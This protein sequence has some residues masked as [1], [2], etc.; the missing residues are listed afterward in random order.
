VKL[1][2]LDV[3]KGTIAF[4]ALPLTAAERGELLERIEGK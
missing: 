2:E 3:G 1:T 4:S